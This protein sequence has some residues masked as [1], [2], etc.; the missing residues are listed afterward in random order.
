MCIYNNCAPKLKQGN[1]L[2]DIGGSLYEVNKGLNRLEIHEKKILLESK[3]TALMV[4]LTTRCNLRC[5]MCSRVRTGQMTLPFELVKKA[6][7]LFPYSGLIDWQGGEVFLVDYFKELFLKAA[8]YPNILQHITTNGLLIDEEWSRIF[9]ESSVSLLYSI[10]SVSKDI[11]ESIRIGAKFEDLLKSIDLVNRFRR[12]S[13]NRNNLEMTTVIM[14]RNYKTLHLFPKFCKKY[15][16]S[17]LTFDLLIPQVIPEEDIVSG[18][19][20]DAI[21]YL[22]KTIPQIENECK[23]NN[24]HFKCTYASFI[25]KVS[26]NFI[27]NGLNRNVHFKYGLKLDNF[28]T[29]CTYPWKRIYIENDGRV[30]PACQCEESIGDLK[31]NSWEEIWNGPVMQSYRNLISIGQAGGICSPKCHF[32]AALERKE[33]IDVFE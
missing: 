1:F 29:D 9:S 19:D 18:P 14:K 5:I 30:Y 20:L 28:V 10:D 11:Y 32:C 13:N 21:L 31:N 24:I 6:Y 12:K 26:N 4:I 17:S 25:N 27:D 23:A 7:A 33:E 2:G 22:N 15:D 16:F 8:S 3:P